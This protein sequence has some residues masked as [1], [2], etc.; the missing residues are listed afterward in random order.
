MRDLLVKVLG[1]GVD[2]LLEVLWLATRYSAAERLVGEAHVHHGGRV[3]F[4]GGKVD[5][6][7]FG[8]QIDLAAVVQVVLLDELAWSGGARSL[9][10]SRAGMSISTLKWPEL[11]TM[12]PF[13]ISSKCSWRS[14][15]LL[16]VT[17]TKT[18]P[19]LA[20]SAMDMTRKPSMT[21]SSARVR[22]DL[23][24]D[25]VGAHAAGAR[26]EAATAP[27]VAGDDELGAGEQDSWCADDAVEGGLA[28]AVAVVEHVLGQRVVDGDDGIREHAFLGH[29][30]QTDDAGGGLFGAGD[31]VCR[32]RPGAWCAAG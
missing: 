2:R 27:A 16:P 15:L 9:M 24:D 32:G 29:G 17:V 8:E 13:F 14:T 10:R 25:D 28:G 20:A 21:A 30:V 12:A 3:T 22:I 11:A 23:G 7:A 19:I 1:H 26:G 5:E 6:A 31:D 18:S 4:G